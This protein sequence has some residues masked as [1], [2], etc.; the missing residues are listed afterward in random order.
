MKIGSKFLVIKKFT[1]TGRGILCFV[2]GG[3]L[4]LGVKVQLP[5]YHNLLNRASS[6]L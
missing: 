2:T 1:S 6:Y 3:T 5:F 4:A